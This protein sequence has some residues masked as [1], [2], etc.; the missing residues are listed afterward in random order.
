LWVT[1]MMVAS[2]RTLATT[3]PGRARIGAL[4]R[5]AL[6][7]QQCHAFRDQCVPLGRLQP[8]FCSGDITTACGFAS[9]VYGEEEIVLRCEHADA[10]YG[11]AKAHA[12]KRFGKKFRAVR[13]SGG[14]GTRFTA[15]KARS[16]ERIR[17]VEPRPLR[18]AFAGPAQG[19]VSLLWRGRRRRA[20]R[21]V[22]RS[23]VLS[24]V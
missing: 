18:S 16:E 19:G 11:R 2:G 1:T 10:P 6:A 12:G 24:R 22:T 17:R 13:T 9:V 4:G 23:P 8:A 7:A 15:P 3:Q 5:E 20:G 21:A 14:R